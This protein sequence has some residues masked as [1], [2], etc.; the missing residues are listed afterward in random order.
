MIS[1]K[2]YKFLYMYPFVY[3]CVKSSFFNGTLWTFLPFNEGH[4][5]YFTFLFQKKK[6]KRTLIW[7]GHVGP[8][9]A[10][11]RGGLISPLISSPKPYPWGVAAMDSCHDAGK[12]P[13]DLLSFTTP[14]LPLS[15][16]PE[17]S[18]FLCRPSLSPSNSL[19]L[20]VRHRTITCL[21]GLRTNTR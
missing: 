3:K 17:F 13:N 18:F 9:I 5:R 4:Q 19:S 16:S 20:Q 7:L 15:P 8:V 12:A 6:K 21:D 1:N 11:E 10:G 2:L 14:S